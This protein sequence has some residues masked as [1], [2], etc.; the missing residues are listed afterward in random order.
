MDLESLGTLGKVA[1]L[2]GIATGVVVLLIRPV[3]G[4]A[5][6]L[7]VAERTPLLRLIA[8]G[9]FGLGALG[10]IA[11]LLSAAPGVK[12]TGGPCSVTS[13]GSASG[14]SVRCGTVPAGPAGE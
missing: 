11:W 14:N 13:A 9:A 2:G 12:V 8:L 1:G 10:I 7:P 4:R 5:S 3:I 6:V